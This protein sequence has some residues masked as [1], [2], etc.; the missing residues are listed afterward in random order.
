MFFNNAA[1]SFFKIKWDFYQKS[2]YIFFLRNELRIK[3][4]LG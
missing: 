1:G 4:H 3:W 2:I